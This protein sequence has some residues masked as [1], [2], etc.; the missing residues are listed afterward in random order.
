MKPNHSSLYL[1][2][3]G[4]FSLLLLLTSSWHYQYRIHDWLAVFFPEDI[5]NLFSGFSYLIG[6]GFGIKS[7]LHFK[8]HYESPHAR[9]MSSNPMIYALIAAF[10]LALPSFLSPHETVYCDSD[11]SGESLQHFQN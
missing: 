8:E 10:F 11:S 6:V 2:Y 3:L 9:L 1:P 4:F 5:I 7:V